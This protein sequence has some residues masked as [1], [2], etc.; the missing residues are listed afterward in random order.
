MMQTRF[1]SLFSGFKKTVPEL[2]IF[3]NP[4]SPPSNSALKLLQ[5]AVSRPY[6]PTQPTRGPLHFD[7]EVVQGPPTQDQLRSI[8]SYVAPGGRTAPGSVFL[9]AHPSAESEKPAEVEEIAPLATQ[10]PNALKWPI[11]V[12]WAAGRASV[13]SVDGV[14]NMLEELRK[15]R[16][17]EAPAPEEYKPKGW[18]S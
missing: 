15:V 17:G 2:T 7:L 18:F 11:V 16:D 9:S 14:K 6:P 3:H 13:G 8:L 5:E 1:Y 10:N 12:D 4:S